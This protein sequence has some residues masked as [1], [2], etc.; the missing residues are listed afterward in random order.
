MSSI[1]PIAATENCYPLFKEGQVL[2]HND[3]N[4]LRDFLYGKWVFHNRALFG[5]GVGCGLDGRATAQDVTIET[6]FA[7]AQSGR[8]L[9]LAQEVTFKWADV[10]GL[11]V[12]NPGDF[13]V[14][15]VNAQA[16][17]YTAV[18][19]PNDTET[20]A[21]QDC[22]PGSC[23]AHTDDWCEG[24]QVVVVRGRLK[25]EAYLS[26][27]AFKLQP[28][29]PPPPQTTDL[30]TFKAAFKQLRD[31][32]VELLKTYG[33]EKPTLDLL[34]KLEIRD[35]EPGINLMKLGIVN[36]VLYTVW[37]YERCRSYDEGDCYVPL[38]KPAVA[39]GWL[40]PSTQVWDCRSRHHFRLS[41][42]LYRAM[43]G[44]RCEDLCAEYL[45]HIRV[46]VQNFEI[47][48]PPPPNDPP[49]KN[50]P[51]VT[52]CDL[53][54]MYIGK[55]HW[56]G[57]KDFTRGQKFV[58]VDPAR[59][60]PKKPAP[61]DP[62][63][64][65]APAGEQP[66][67]VAT[68]FGNFDPTGS[69]IVHLTEYIGYDGEASRAAVQKGVPG[70]VHVLKNEELGGVEGIESALVGAGSDQIYFGVD[71]RGAVVS[72]AVVA[73]AQTLQGVPAIGAT[74]A[75]A[76]T[77]ANQAV[78]EA[79]KATQVAQTAAQDALTAKT[80]I[81]TVQ[82]SFS[83]LRAEWTTFKGSI[84]E[85][86]TLNTAG[87]AAESF[88]SVEAKLTEVTAK[89]EGIQADVGNHKEV[90][91]K[92]AA[93]VDELDQGH[94][95]LGQKLEATKG[96]LA[97]SIQAA[98]DEVGA[99]KE[100]LTRVEQGQAGVE[101]DL[102]TETQTL[103]ARID[104]VVSPRVEPILPTPVAPTPVAP[105]PGMLTPPAAPG[106]GILTPPVGLVP[107]LVV[108]ALTAMR[109]AVETAAPRSKV[110]QVRERLA[111]AD[112]HLETLRIH[113]ESGGS[114]PGDQPDALAE[115]LVA[116][117]DAV[118]AAGLDK[119]SSEYR[120]LTKSVTEL[121]KALGLGARRRR[122]R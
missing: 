78:Q 65:R 81:G 102:K 74:A 1:G 100:I 41:T 76:K 36:E 62:V 7:L 91:D 3:L 79:G 116:L 63:E 42:A 8:S 72:T 12:G 57:K 4:L 97:T 86:G 31:A 98:H 80:G 39:L 13:G 20:P 45:D 121:R 83:S 68:N 33:I 64:F 43:R 46:I 103:R 60:L 49:D 15:F 114:L 71:D 34:T 119:R 50:P 92:T 19:V 28:L 69:G 14:D 37:E 96:E 2:T 24:A 110:A 29:E 84:P 115:A 9:E 30:T 54:E 118:A 66:W 55:C 99:Q 61:G 88:A 32:L 94:A 106:P 59:K 73:T 108:H 6:G 89:V 90:L 112:P 58:T 25:A 107:G 40:D 67:D 75:D 104:Q 22:T 52:L 27:P 77:N 48:K 47:P 95:D 10:D 111:A 117:T 26:S 16:A 38:G 17:G 85:A 70:E 93:K 109:S 23:A 5:F 11:A 82:Q 51:H 113:A 87:R 53:K 120:A 35:K 105:G 56:S 18:L 101:Q 122:K 21:S 44:Y